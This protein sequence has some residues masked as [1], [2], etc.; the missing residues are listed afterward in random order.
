MEHAERN[1]LDLI[2]IN[3]TA[4]PPVCKI[5]DHGKMMYEKSKRE[6]ASRKTRSLQVK[7]VQLKP[8]IGGND[9]GRKVG[10]IQKFLDKGHRVVVQVAMKGRQRAYPQ[11]AEEIVHYIHNSLEGSTLETSKLSRSSIACFVKKKV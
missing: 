1:G 8:N 2:E 11:Q 3:S 7:T 6:K 5:A 10:H 9:L 4:S